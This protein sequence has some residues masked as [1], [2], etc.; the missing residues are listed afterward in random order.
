MCVAYRFLKRRHLRAS[1]QAESRFR[2]IFM[3]R[4]V[5]GLGL[6]VRTTFDRLIAE[7]GVSDKTVPWAD[8]M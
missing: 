3:D 7:H 6:I 2:V 4:N 5:D 8:I 1:Q